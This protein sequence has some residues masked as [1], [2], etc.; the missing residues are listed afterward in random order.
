VNNT[1]GSFVSRSGPFPLDGQEVR[2]VAH[3]TVEL[4]GTVRGDDGKPLASYITATLHRDG[5]A[6]ETGS[7]DETGAFTLKVPLGENV[8]LWAR[9]TTPDAGGA[10]FTGFE[11]RV[12]GVTGPRTNVE[13][14][15]HCV[16]LAYDRALTV[17][18]EDSTGVP[19]PDVEIGV[20]EYNPSKSWKVKTDADG[21][22]RFEGLANHEVLLNFAE[23]DTSPPQHA[24][25]V[26]PQRALVTPDGQEFVVKWRAGAAIRGRVVD[27]RGRGVAD[28]FIQVATPDGTYIASHTDA[29]GR[30]R[31]YGLPSQ[32]HQLLAQGLVD[33]KPSQGTV[34]KV[35]P[36]DAEVTLTLAPRAKQAK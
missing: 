12:N 2:V 18:V 28:G 21:R 1:D 14:V 6:A 32:L 29:D 4:R 13:I 26:A 36:G 22:A 8:D 23:R 34:E 11:G 20:Y 9:G 10:T 35:V 17:I 16:K 5:S 19:V 31:T 30:F 7:S 24:L 27:P 15:L 33:G 3:R 25:D